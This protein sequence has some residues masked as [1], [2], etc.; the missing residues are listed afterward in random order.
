MKQEITTNFEET[1][2]YSFNDKE[3]LLQSLTTKAFSIENGSVPYRDSLANL[4]DAI[5]DAIVVEWGIIK[6]GYEEKGV[7]DSLRQRLCNEESLYR[8]MLLIVAKHIISVDITFHDCF[9]VGRGE[10]KERHYTGER[11]LA[12]TLEAIVG[13]IHIDGGFESAKTVVINHIIQTSE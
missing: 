13:A 9:R 12:E 6:L 10:R 7:L 1:L 8:K 11:Y 4:G 3:L 5:I 2:K